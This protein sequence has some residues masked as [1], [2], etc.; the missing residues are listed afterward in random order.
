MPDVAPTYDLI[1]K[2]GVVAT[3]LVVIAF[4]VIGLLRGWIVTGAHH[5]ETKARADKAEEL[6]K[7]TV[8]AV[9]S[10]RDEMREQ[11]LER[12]ARREWTP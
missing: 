4:L 7:D 3:L 2:G 5:T 11:R 12:V 1:D 9:A 10:I 6:L 8:T